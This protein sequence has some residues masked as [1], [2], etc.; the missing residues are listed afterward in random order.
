MAIPRTKNES[1]PSPY[2][3]PLVENWHADCAA[4]VL[5]LGHM[6]RREVTGCTT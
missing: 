1:H 6:V 2:S 5:R 4:N 3:S